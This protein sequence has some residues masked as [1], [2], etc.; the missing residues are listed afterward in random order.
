[1]YFPVKNS[2]SFL[3]KNT[4]T[5]FI[6]HGTPANA[7]ISLI[8]YTSVHNVQQMYTMYSCKG[9]ASGFKK[10]AICVKIWQKTRLKHTSTINESEISKY[11]WEQDMKSATA[12]DTVALIQ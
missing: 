6:N 2:R 5:D 12:D 9:H 3:I 7:G 4:K 11:Q 8:E 1:M 10:Q